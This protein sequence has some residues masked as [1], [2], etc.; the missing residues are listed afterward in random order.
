MPADTLVFKRRNGK[1]I[2]KILDSMRNGHGHEKCSIVVNMSDYHDV[3]L[4]LED[5]RSMWDVPIDKSIE[6]Y[7]KNRAENLWPF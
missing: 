3:A 5:L 7:K 6:E 1:N 4:F 2:V